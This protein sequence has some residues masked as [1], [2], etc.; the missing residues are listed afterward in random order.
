MTGV[1]RVLFRSATLVH[2]FAIGSSTS[3]LAD[4]LSWTTVSVDSGAGPS[5]TASG[6]SLTEGST[7]YVS[8][9][10]TDTDIQVSDTTTTDG[11]T[12]D[13]TA[14]TIASVAEG[15]ATGD[16]DYQN[17]ASQL[18]ISWSGSDGASGIT[19]Y[20]YSLGTTS[21]GTETI[22]WTSTGTTTA[23]TLTGLS[24]LEGSTYYLSTRATDVAGNVS[25]IVTGDE[26]GR[27][28]V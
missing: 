3:T 7:Y 6:L 15:S 1:Q 16:A 10:A 21:G 14:P 5:Y 12:I 27:A 26:I 9:R 13:A 20:E 4:I 25:D 8:V 22:D 28:H 11:V 24:L 2:E 17:D 19:T 18:I 23:D